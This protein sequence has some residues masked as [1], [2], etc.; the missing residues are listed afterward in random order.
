MQ[1]LFI[2]KVSDKGFWQSFSNELV[3]RIWC[4]YRSEECTVYYLNGEQYSFRC[5]CDFYNSQYGTPVSNDGERL[6]I[7]HWE[8]NKGLCCYSIKDN[9][10]IWRFKGSKNRN[11]FVYDGFL[12]VIKAETSILKVDEK[13]GKISNEKRS[14]TIHKAF[15]IQDK[16]ILVNNLK[17]RLTLWDTGRMQSVKQYDDHIVNPNNCLSFIINDVALSEGVLTIGGFESN[18]NGIYVAARNM[19]IY[20]RVIDTDIYETIHKYECN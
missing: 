16:Y 12:I 1:P 20:N 13:T 3:D 5:G 9:K 10:L 2:E 17:G 8:Y 14:G 4:D 15:L 18:P 11:V 6:F 19:D 7:G